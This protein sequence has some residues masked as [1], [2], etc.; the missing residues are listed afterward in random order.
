MLKVSALLGLGKDHIMAKFKISYNAPVTLTFALLSLLVLL[1]DSLTGN[2]VSR[3]FFTVYPDFH[4]ASL[5]SYFRL[6]SHIF[7]HSGWAHLVS[8]FSFILLIGPILEEKYGSA[9]LLEM[10]GI[11][12]L[13]TGLLTVTVLQSGLMGASGIVFMLILLSSFT[14]IR[15]RQIPLTF[16]LIALLFL[17]QE[18]ISGFKSDNISQFA[19]LVGGVFGGLFGFFYAGERRSVNR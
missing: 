6:I 14:N 13:V 3:N 10:M 17:S 15:A 1:G 16:I 4:A 12:A 2:A 7:G 11:T 19:H 18:L 9:A 8:N 5:L